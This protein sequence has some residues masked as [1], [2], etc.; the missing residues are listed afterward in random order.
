MKIVT[1][2]QGH[3]DCGKLILGMYSHVRNVHAEEMA[4]E[5]DMPIGRKTM[6]T[7]RHNS[8]P[9]SILAARFSSLGSLDISSRARTDFNSVSHGV[10]PEENRQNG[11]A[12]VV[13]VA[14]RA[15]EG[16]RASLLPMPVSRVLV[17]R[18]RGDRRGYFT[19]NLACL[20]HSLKRAGASNRTVT[21]AETRSSR[22]IG[23]D[24]ASASSSNGKRFRYRVTSGSKA[25]RE[26]TIPPARAQSSSGEQNIL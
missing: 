25:E 22:S 7:P 3:Y 24:A 11:Q 6:L 14:E 10:A 13:A 21:P 2:L 17:I 12:G 20:C 5:V 16:A 8:R 18:L 1:P 19:C 15:N 26:F 23:A 4:Q 9:A